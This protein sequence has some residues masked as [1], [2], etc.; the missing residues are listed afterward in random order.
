MKS[1]GVIV[2]VLF[3]LRVSNGNAQSPSQNPSTSQDH[4]D[5]Q[6]LRTF[7]EKKN[8]FISPASIKVSLAMLLEGAKHQ[9]A[10]EIMTALGL[11][12]S[13]V[14]DELQ[15]L[16]EDLNASTNATTVQSANGVFISNTSAVNQQY[17]QI[18]QKD[19]SADI[20]HLDYADSIGSSNLINNWVKNRSNGKIENIVS[21]DSFSA[22][23]GLILANALYFKGLWKTVFEERSTFLRCF[24]N[25]RKDCI[26]A[27]MMQTDGKFNYKSIA[28]L[29][30]QALQ[31]QYGDGEYAMLILLPNQAQTVDGLIKAMQ[32]YSFSSI[33]SQLKSDEVF[34]NIPRFEVDFNADISSLLQHVGITQVFSDNADLSGI[35]QDEK[36]K[37]SQ[38]VHKAKVEVNE[39]GTVASATTVANISP[40]IGGSK[41]RFIVDHPFLFFIYQVESNNIL[42]EGRFNEP[43]DAY[44]EIFKK[45]TS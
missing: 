20:R 39:K 2:L 13:S 8:Y 12:S 26:N 11:S 5:I 34:V 10:Q 44:D 7:D 37:V 43:P 32:S 22:G 18:L 21:P 1:V 45:P 38:V 15:L 3:V 41:P 24:R 42:F 36:L 33:T 17:Q 14:K 28:A 40:L 23:T 4:F 30:A 9:T 27:R 6:L 31:L 19:Y 29:D 16:L 25:H 35:T